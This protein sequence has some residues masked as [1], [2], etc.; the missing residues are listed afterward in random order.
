MSTNTFCIDL[1]LT[2]GYSG[3]EGVPA[4]PPADFGIHR[5]GGVRQLAGTLGTPRAV[6]EITSDARKYFDRRGLVPPSGSSLT[7]KQTSEPGEHQGCVTV[8]VAPVSITVC[9]TWEDDD[10]E[11]TDD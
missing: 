8:A 1:L 2:N 11:G 5:R 9:S 4:G 7:A 3:P 10:D 6:K